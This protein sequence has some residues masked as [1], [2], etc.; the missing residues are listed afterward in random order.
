MFLP[1]RK[2]L[3]Q[4]QRHKDT[5]RIF[6]IAVERSAV[7]KAKALIEPPRRGKNLSGTGLETHA[8]V[9]PTAGLVQDVLEHAAGDAL[10]QV[11]RCSTHR[12]DFAMGFVQFLERA[13]AQ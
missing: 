3:L 9:P 11:S 1:Q 7:R 10:P 12:F 5:E 6:D 8:P 4:F 13:A 2:E